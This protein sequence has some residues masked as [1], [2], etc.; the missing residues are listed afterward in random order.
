MKEGEKFLDWK[1]CQEWSAPSHYI[2]ALFPDKTTKENP[3]A[4]VTDPVHTK[5]GIGCATARSRSV[6]LSKLSHFPSNFLTESRPSVSLT[7]R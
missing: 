5:N 2:H 1:F 3:K 7:A 6:K 4:E